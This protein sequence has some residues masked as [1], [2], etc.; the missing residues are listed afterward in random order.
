MTYSYIL[1]T[2]RPDSKDIASFASLKKG[3]EGTVLFKPSN[4][5]GES[6]HGRTLQCTV[7]NMDLILRFMYRE[8]AANAILYGL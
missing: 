3:T 6:G 4:K 1:T 7:S 2:Y 8:E 5:S